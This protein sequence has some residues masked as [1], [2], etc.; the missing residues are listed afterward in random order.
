[1]REREHPGSSPATLQQLYAGLSALIVR[2]IDARTLEVEAEQ[3]WGAAPTEHVFA[4]QRHLRALAGDGPQL[5]AMRVRVMA[6]TRDGRPARVRFAFP[7][8]LESP[9]RTWLCWTGSH[10]VPFRLPA[11]GEDVRLPALSLFSAME[12]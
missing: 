10:P 3:G 2:R 8:A 11:I 1:V 7:S 4:N 6:T 9:E 5:R 12:P